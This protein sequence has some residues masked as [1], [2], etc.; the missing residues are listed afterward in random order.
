MADYKDKRAI[1]FFKMTPTKKKSTKKR[2]LDESGP[3]DE[4]DEL[5]S[6]ADRILKRKQEAKEP[7]TS[8]ADTIVSDTVS[9]TEDA[10]E[11]DKINE[12]ELYSLK[13]EK[14]LKRSS[15]KMLNDIDA[16]VADVE[17]KLEAGKKADAEKREVLKRKKMFKDL[18]DASALMYASKAGI[19]ADIGKTGDNEDRDA[20][21]DL[22]N[23]TSQRRTELRDRLNRLLVRPKKERETRDYILHQEQRL[24]EKNLALEN[25][26][27]KDA[28]KSGLRGPDSE[29]AAKK[30]KRWRDE[31]EA[32]MKK[33]KEDGSDFKQNMA[34]TSIPDSI[35][36][37]IVEASNSAWFWGE[38]FD[39]VIYGAGSPEE[40]R[41]LWA[42]EANRELGSAGTTPDGGGSNKI[43]DEIDKLTKELGIK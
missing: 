19:Q 40:T 10:D 3:E 20:E 26:M 31:A 15:A 32:A 1:D 36:G 35:K 23:F 39:E 42:G 12:G 6:L 33:S 29:K 34:T 21:L 30:M 7:E 43:Q 22:Q 13:T 28:E 37:Q 25:K 18:I 38:D 8:T 2:R 16:A 11:G 17:K 41:A 9:E 14:A 5:Q 27:L 24:H 4:A